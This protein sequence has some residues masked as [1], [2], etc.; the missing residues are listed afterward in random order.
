MQIDQIAYATRNL[1]LAEVASGRLT[2][3]DYIRE[4]ADKSDMEV[5]VR[6]LL[7]QKWMD[8]DY[9]IDM[10][11]MMVYFK[12]DREVLTGIIKQYESELINT[13]FNIK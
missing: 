11:R 3:C 1:K 10:E 6:V 2:L 13:K 8:G 5:A 9:D 12:T 4:Y 7:K